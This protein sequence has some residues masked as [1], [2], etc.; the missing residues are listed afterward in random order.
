[1]GAMWL[2]LR[3]YP[4]LYCGG[5]C[6]VVFCGVRPRRHHSRHVRWQEAEVFLL[7]RG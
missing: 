4:A 1:M 6:G 2:R 5:K 7:T 3:P